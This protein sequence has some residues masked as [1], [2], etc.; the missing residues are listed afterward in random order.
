MSEEEARR[1]FAAH[2]PVEAW[3]GQRLVVAAVDADSGLRTVFDVHSGVR[4]LDA[5]MASC[6]SPGVFPLVT[7]NG[8]RYADGGL[9]S[10][11]NIDLAVGYDVVTVLS[12]LQLNPHLQQALDAEVASLVGATVHVITADEVSLA[13]IGPNLLSQETAT[14]A[15]DAGQ[16]QA[17]RESDALRSIWHSGN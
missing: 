5:V 6:A 15:L 10:P 11:Y 14:A 12:P 17:A 1:L 4:L 13:A 8:R 16:A 2:L 9:R 3:P 7:I